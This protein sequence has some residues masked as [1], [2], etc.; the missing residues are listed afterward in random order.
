[1]GMG[2]GEEKVEA[3]LKHGGN[4]S[5]FGLC[6]KRKTSEG[7]H[8]DEMNEKRRKIDK[9]LREASVLREYVCLELRIYDIEA[10]GCT[11]TPIFP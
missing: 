2:K 5:D 6:K 3:A 11:E 4:S 7:E 9:Y 8:S 1:M 10:I